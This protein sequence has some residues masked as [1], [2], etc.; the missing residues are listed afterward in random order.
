MWVKTTKWKTG[1]RKVVSGRGKLKSW[2]ESFHR[3][4][5]R[6]RNWQRCEDEGWRGRVQVGLYN[7]LLIDKSQLLSCSCCY[8][9]QPSLLPGSFSTSWTTSTWRRRRG[10]GSRLFAR[11]TSAS[12]WEQSMR[13]LMRTQR[14]VF[15]VCIVFKKCTLKTIGKV[16]TS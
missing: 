9:H 15:L 7:Q 16:C 14:F 8:F 11:N 2:K 4:H 5:G 10:T 3:I 13:I 1:L 6:V 12:P